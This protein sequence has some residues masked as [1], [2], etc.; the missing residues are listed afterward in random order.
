[1]QISRI[2]I[3]MSVAG[4]KKAEMRLNSTA[5]PASNID[6]CLVTK[7]QSDPKKFFCN[8]PCFLLQKDGGESY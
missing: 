6:Q 7:P 4:S 1:M 2:Y 5:N 3:Y 8:P